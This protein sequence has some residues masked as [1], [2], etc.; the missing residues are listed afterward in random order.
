MKR[1]NIIVYNIKA[2][3]SEKILHNFVLQELIYRLLLYARSG[4]TKLLQ[5]NNS[6]FQWSTILHSTLQL[7]VN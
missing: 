1:D 4:K 6:S 5:N 2:I 7:H 3:V